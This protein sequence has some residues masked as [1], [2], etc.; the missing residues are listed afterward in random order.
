LTDIDDAAGAPSQAAAGAARRY[1]EALLGFAQEME[2]LYVSAGAPSLSVLVESS[3]SSGRGAVSVGGLSD[4]LRGRRFPSLDYTITMVRLLT[5]GQVQ[6]AVLDQWRA[7]WRSVKLLQ[8]AARRARGQARTAGLDVGE[9]GSTDSRP[10]P[11]A[12][13]AA[14]AAEVH[15]AGVSAHQER[16]LACQEC[17]IW[18]SRMRHQEE[19]RSR[20]QA[21]AGHLIEALMQLW[22][23]HG[24]QLFEPGGSPPALAFT[25]GGGKL[26]VGSAGGLVSL[27]DPVTGNRAGKVFFHG[28]DVDVLAVDR[29]DTMLV[30]ASR[31][32]GLTRFWDFQTAQL[33]VELRID[34]ADSLRAIAVSSEVD[35]V[36]ALSA[37]SVELWEGATNKP[38]FK[39]VRPHASA[40]AVS[41]DGCYVAVADTMGE[42]SLFQASPRERMCILTP[43]GK[44]V[45]MIAFSCATRFLGVVDAYGDVYTW[46]LESLGEHPVIL[47]AGTITGQSVRTL[48]F[49]PDEEYLVTGREDG[50]V[51]AWSLAGGLPPVGEALVSPSAVPV[52]ALAVSDD[53]RIVAVGDEDGAVSLRSLVAAGLKVDSGATDRNRS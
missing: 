47:I 31:E 7:R 37:D 52:A 25:Q 39:A 21:R 33:E 41:Y 38:L 15:S 43:Q 4:V 8:R 30:T 10:V 28:S 2:R 16:E 29:D 20:E 5:K 14:G 49:S 24:L 1:P 12:P 26:A 51:Q 45:Q 6:A 46:R 23:P 19:L 42:V 35:V 53:N 50:T 27:W 18:E 9:I 22:P 36:A 48:A 17:G 40:M 44:A 13:P 3:R 34:G 32:D 11:L